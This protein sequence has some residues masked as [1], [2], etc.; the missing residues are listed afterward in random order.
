MKKRKSLCALLAAIMLMGVVAGC[1]SAPAP[2]NSSAPG[3]SQSGAPKDS[4]NQKEIKLS[5]MMVS[6]SATKLFTDEFDVPAKFKEK[7][8]NVTVDF[9]LVKG[10]TLSVLKMRD[11][12]D[13]LP[14]IIVGQ[15]DWQYAIKDRLEKL[16]DLDCVKNN[17]YAEDAAIDGNVFAVNYESFYN[18]TFYRK[19]IF[20]KYNLEIPKT[21]DEYIKVIETINEK[22]EYIPLAV[23]GK[24]EWPLYPYGMDAAIISS[25]KASALDEMAATDSPFSEGQPS[26]AAFK[27]LKQLTDLKAFGSDPLGIGFDESKTFL[28]TASKAAMFPSSQW[29]LGDVKTSAGGNLDNIGVFFTPYREKESDPL[30]AVTEIGMPFMVTKSENSEMAKTFVNWMFNSDLYKSYLE[31]SGLI[32]TVTTVETPYAP[33]FKEAID[34]AKDLKP[35]AKIKTESFTK[36]VT[37]AKFNFDTVSAAVLSGKDLNELMEQN[38][39]A[40]KTAKAE[41]N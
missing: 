12:A 4:G 8:P 31:K 28:G 10:D 15:L 32:S 1:Q 20:K 24:D 27:K 3:A 7:Y 34:A 36:M 21:W 11:Q 13:E 14:D 38:N 17:L 6:E 18:C 39:T 41:L 30:Y 5:V 19:D 35:I 29:A 40:W 25:G 37:A 2:G 23:G 22:G 16:N 33:I 26:Y 9:E